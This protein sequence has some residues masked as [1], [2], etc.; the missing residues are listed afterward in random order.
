MNVLGVIPARGGSKGIPRKNLCPLHGR[1]LLAYTIDSAHESLRLSRT[2]L[3]SDDPEILEVGRAL[4][5]EVP[6]VRPAALSG[7]T[8]GSAEVVRHA[9]DAMETTGER[10]EAVVLLEPTAP[11]RTGADIDAAIDR[12]ESSGTDSVVSV[13]RVD[14]PHPIKMQRIEGDRLL[15]FL[16]DHWREGL[17]RQG[18]PPV[19]AL[20][21]AVYAVRAD[22]MRDT[23]SLWGRT[24]A[25]LVMPA[26]RS[27]N[28]DSALDLVLAEVLLTRRR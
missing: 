19:Y 10:F 5:V 6:F 4:G 18:L 7:D 8:T 14:A 13:C 28:I 22:V 24:T 12:L 9:L 17:T 20:N 3:S 27:V 26:E 15:P 2:V 23:G 25:P 1:P 16:P 11:L 21:G